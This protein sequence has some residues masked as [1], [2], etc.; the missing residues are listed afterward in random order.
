[1][2]GGRLHVLAFKR[3]LNIVQ[4]HFAIRIWLLRQML[5]RVPDVKL[6][7]YYLAYSTANLLFEALPAGGRLLA[8]SCSATERGDYHSFL[9][10]F[11][12]LLTTE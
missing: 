7:L 3:S 12:A 4:L 5:Y 10:G 8:P 1:M 9:E 2:I 11:R 6:Y